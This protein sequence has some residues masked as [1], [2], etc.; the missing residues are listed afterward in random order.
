MGAMDKGK[1]D[2]L[3]RE[4]D[5]LAM[6]FRLAPKAGEPDE[7]WLR[8]VRL[9]IGLSVVEVARRL[10]VSKWAIYGFRE[11]G[12]GMADQAG[13]AAP[14]RGGAE[15]RPGVCAGSAGRNDAGVGGATAGGRG[16]GAREAEA[17]REGAVEVAG[18]A[19][20]RAAG[21][22]GERAAAGGTAWITAGGV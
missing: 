9:A 12:A 13:D 18:V 1:K 11:I 20:N 10:K 5:D 8:A 2:E 17:F 3:R 15:L 4:L 6:G 14:G 22:A 7:G 19:G 16:S 21:L